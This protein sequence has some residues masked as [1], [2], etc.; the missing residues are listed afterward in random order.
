MRNDE[1]W[2]KAW[3]G[4]GLVAKPEPRTRGGLRGVEEGEAAA[5]ADEF[6]DAQGRPVE[7][8]QIPGSAVSPGSTGRRDD[9][10][11]GAM[12]ESDGGTGMGPQQRLDYRDIAAM[13]VPGYYY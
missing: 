3:A 1:Y 2:R 4:S 7:P 6:R 9:E 12:M 11:A 8:P 10:G 13:A 5:D